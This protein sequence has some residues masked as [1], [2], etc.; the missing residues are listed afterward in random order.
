MTASKPHSVFQEAW[1]YL[2]LDDPENRVEPT[3]YQ[4]ALI[5]GLLEQYEDACRKR[6]EW[7]QSYAEE[8]GRLDVALRRTQEQLETYQQENERWRQA[9]KEAFA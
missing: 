7:K 1:D 4:D 8:V 6:D 9:S 5:Y 2:G 3:D